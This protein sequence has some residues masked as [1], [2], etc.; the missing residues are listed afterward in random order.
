MLANL[1]G[2]KTVK[3]LAEMGKSMAKA[4]APHYSGRT[5]KMIIVRK[6]QTP[7]GVVA[8]IIAQNPTKGGAHRYSEGQYRNF[9]LVRWMH[10]TKGVYQSHNPFGPKPKHIRSGDPQFMFTTRRFL[11]K[12]KKGVAT[13]QFRRI[14]LR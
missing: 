9:N 5:A 1:A 2:R 7:E 4:I 10:Q 8:Q 13:G 12:T 6:K 3:Q 14:N 11:N